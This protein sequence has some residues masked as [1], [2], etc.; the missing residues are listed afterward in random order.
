M[1][2]KTIKNIDLGKLSKQLRNFERQWI[3]ISQENKIVANGDT[4]GEA[5]QKVQKKDLGE[6]ILFKVPPLDYS[7]SP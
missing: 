3:A 5:L 4:Y 6:V 7:F 1:K 2:E